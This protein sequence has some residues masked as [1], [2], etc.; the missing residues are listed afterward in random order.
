MRFKLALIGLCVPCLAQTQL[1]SVA[2]INLCTDQLVLTVADPDQIVSLS[3]LSA[4]PAE[5]MLASQ[6]ASY[7]LNYG[8]AEELVAIGADVV[9]ADLIRA[10]VQSGFASFSSAAMPAVSG[11]DIDVPL[12][13]W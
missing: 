4:H 1:P 7:P 10:G 6:A 13:Y 8:S 3:W 9:S 12:R 5:S 2:S 11:A